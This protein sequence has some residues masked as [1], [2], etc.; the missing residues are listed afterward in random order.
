M[1]YFYKKQVI[2]IASLMFII[3]LAGS[4]PTFYYLLTNRGSVS[5][6][7][8]PRPPSIQVSHRTPLISGQPVAISIPSVDINIPVINGYYNQRT[9]DWSLSLDKAQFATPTV[10]P[11]NQTGNTFIYGHYRLGV[12][13]TLPHVQ[14]G[15]EATII[16][17]NGYKFTYKFYST[18]A[19]QPTDL[20][21]L[22]YKGP[23]MLT[24]QTC[25]GTWYQ[26]RQMYL[27]SYVG[28]QKAS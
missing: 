10:I 17:D 15:A 7:A 20:S 5:S 16:T 25:S 21:V 18:Y 14:S 8:L 22:T 28:Y 6:H 11:N 3:G 13:Y 1:K 19:T 23:P 2:I 26:N 12:F 24:L 4:L 9:K 27:F